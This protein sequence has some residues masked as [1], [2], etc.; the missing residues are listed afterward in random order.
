MFKTKT[1]ILS[2]MHLE[3]KTLDS[4]TTSLAVP[5]VPRAYANIDIILLLCCTCTYR[6]RI[7]ILW[8]SKVPEIHEFL[9]I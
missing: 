3:T 8:I 5:E 7:R 2:S 9:R 1:Y 4:R 6:L